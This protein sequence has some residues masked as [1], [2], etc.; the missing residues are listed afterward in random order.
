MI[1]DMPDMIVIQT[2]VFIPYVI[3]HIKLHLL[4]NFF[5]NVSLGEMYLAYHTWKV[6]KTPS[7][8]WYSD[9]LDSRGPRRNWKGYPYNLVPLHLI[10]HEH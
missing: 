5:Q 9:V 4:F 10:Y 3:A 1:F 7:L 2:A 6:P 8:I